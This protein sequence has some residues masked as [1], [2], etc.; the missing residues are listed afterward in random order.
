[1]QGIS[2]LKDG[3]QVNSENFIYFPKSHYKDLI[4][5]SLD[6]LKKDLDNQFLFA[7][8]PDYSSKFA[9]LWLEVNGTESLNDYIKSYL[10]KDPSIVANV[11]YAF[12][13]I[14]RSSGKDGI[15]YRGDFRINDFLSL[16]NIVDSEVICQYAVKAVGDSMD[17]KIEFL[18]ENQTNDNRIKQFIYCYHYDKKHRG[19]HPLE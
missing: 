19:N 7:K 12:T 8:Y 4:S 5:F 17:Y 3:A 10:N 9:G 16:K 15:M 11:I 13:S 18:A 14:E 6:M 1:M 2:I